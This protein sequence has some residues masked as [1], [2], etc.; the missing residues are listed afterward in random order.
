[1]VSDVE[2]DSGRIEGVTVSCP[3]CKQ[4]VSVMGVLTYNKLK[5]NQRFPHWARAWFCHYCGH[6]LTKENIKKS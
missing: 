1:M 4:V 6:R 5:D 3:Y 2:S